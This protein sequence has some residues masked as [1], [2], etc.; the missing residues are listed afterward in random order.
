MSAE[1]ADVDVA[2]GE[3][4]HRGPGLG[5]LDEPPAKRGHA[6]GTGA[7]DHQLRALEQQHDRLGDRV[8]VDGHQLVEQALEQRRRDLA[9]LLDRD[10]VGE[11]AVRLD[12]D[13]LDVVAC[14]P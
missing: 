3:D 12:P 10:P 4:H 13:H 2:P 8:L 14:S 5:R 7:L 6:D 1:N 11:R 9:R